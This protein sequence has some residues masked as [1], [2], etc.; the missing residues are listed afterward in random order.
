MT[1]VVF[2]YALDKRIAGPPLASIHAKLVDMEKEEYT[3]EDFPNPRGEIHVCGNTMFA[4]YWSNLPLT[5]DA[6]HPDGCYSTGMVGEIFP[7]GSILLLEP[8]R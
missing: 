3:A 7:N 6:I 2:Y 5:L 8:S 1:T 4:G